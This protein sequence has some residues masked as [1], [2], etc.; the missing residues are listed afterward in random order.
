MEYSEGMG[1]EMPVWVIQTSS[2]KRTLNRKT[3]KLQA[4]VTEECVFNDPNEAKVKLQ[5]MDFGYEVKQKRHYRDSKN[6]R[7]W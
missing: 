1:I 5:L 4:E 6:S 7:I 2:G 3:N